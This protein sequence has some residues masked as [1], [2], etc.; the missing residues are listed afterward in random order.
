MVCLVVVAQDVMGNFF[1]LYSFW[2]VVVILGL[3]VQSTQH[4]Q[5]H[6]VELLDVGN[7]HKHV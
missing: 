4:E 5:K 1:N 2:Y 6:S 7:Q 3:R